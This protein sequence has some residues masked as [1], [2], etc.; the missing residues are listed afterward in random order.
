[1]INSGGKTFYIQYSKRKIVDKS[2]G[3]MFHPHLTAFSSWHSFRRE[4]LNYKSDKAFQLDALVE[5]KL[6]VEERLGMCSRLIKIHK[7]CKRLELG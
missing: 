6:K 3:I 1:M 5:K 4:N 7:E 2:F